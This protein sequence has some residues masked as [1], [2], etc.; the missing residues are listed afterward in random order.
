M[1]QNHARREL[2]ARLTT[3]GISLLALTAQ[4]PARAAWEIV[5]DL[6]LSANSERNPRL[7][8]SNLT[9]ASSTATSGALDAALDLATFNE[10]SQL[11]LRPSLSSTRYVDNTNGDLDGDEYFFKGAGY[12]RW[13]TVTAGFRADYARERLL[14][15]ELVTVNPDN[16]PD[17]QDPGF[18]ETGRLVFISQDRKRSRFTPYLNFRVSERNTLRV[19]VTKTD[20][21]YS[22]GNLSFR[23]GY[24]D[25]SAS[26]G[27]IRNVDQ[28]N[29]VSA[30]MS[31]DNYKADVNQNTTDT[32]RIEGA[33]SRPVSQLWTMNL[34]VG[35]LRADFDVL[36]GPLT[37]PQQRTS[38]AATDYTMRFGLRKRTER[39][40]INFDL[41]RNAYG[42]SSGVSSVYRE[43]RAYVNREMTQRLSASFG[44]RLQESESLGNINNINDRRYS[45][46]EVDFEWAI[47]PVLYLSTGYHYTA[48]EFINDPTEGKRDKNAIYV[49]VGYR[50]L[51][52]R[53]SR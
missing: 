51:S 7:N 37:G 46:V 42:S 53:Q 35:V 16:N 50:G 32:V 27:I 25:T 34:G 30:V 40:K 17:T 22:G 15:S 52:R 49:G 14:S 41:T 39:S 48:E 19:D 20:V 18:G 26:A 5:P 4:Q 29:Q 21:W 28:R 47:K 33:F 10:R 43:V 44:V 3:A 31:V 6:N 8:P 2:V 36:T 13:E 24:S 45:R 12:F 11:T 1:K 38:S 23:T 9:V